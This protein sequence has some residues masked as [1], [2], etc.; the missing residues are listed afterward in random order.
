[1]VYTQNQTPKLEKEN[2]FSGL[3]QPVRLKQLSNRVRR[4]QSQK[5]LC[6]SLAT[7]VSPIPRLPRFRGRELFPDSALRPSTRSSA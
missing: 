6:Q 1:M 5:Q 3:A 4:L 7:T 2:Y